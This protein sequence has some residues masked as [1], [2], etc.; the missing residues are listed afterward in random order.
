[1]LCRFKVYDWNRVLIT[2]ILSNFYQI[3]VI[4][5]VVIVHVFFFRFHVFGDRYFYN[6]VGVAIFVLTAHGKYMIGGGWGG[7]ITSMHTC[8]TM[9]CYVD[10]MCLHA[11]SSTWSPHMESI[12][13]G[14][15][16]GVGWGGIITSMHACGTMWCYVDGMFLHAGSSTWSPHMESIWLGGWGG[17][18]GWDN[19]VHARLRNYVMLR[20]WNV[21]ACW[22]LYVVTA[23]GKYMIGGVGGWGGII[24][25]MHACGTMWCYKLIVVGTISKKI[26]PVK[27]RTALAQQSMR[28][29]GIESINGSIATTCPSER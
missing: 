9:W 7:I 12:W 16:G 27:W 29:S 1:M 23:H 11:G 22:Q 24:T 10:G 18:V 28:G 3:K 8:G 5:K 6:R 19:N 17:G 21:P 4:Q 15:V 14:G 13:L 20:W 25:S 2:M 26:A